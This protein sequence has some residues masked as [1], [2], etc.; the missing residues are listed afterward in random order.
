MKHCRRLG[1]ILWKSLQTLLRSFC[2]GIML[3]ESFTARLA[4]SEEH[5]TLNLRLV[6]LGPTLAAI[7]LQL[8]GLSRS[9]YC[10]GHSFYNFKCCPGISESALCHIN[11]S[12]GGISLPW[13]PSHPRIVTTSFLLRYFRFRPGGQPGGWWIN[14]G[15]RHCYFLMMSNGVQWFPSNPSKVLC[16]QRSCGRYS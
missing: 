3:G 8:Q 12:F 4:Q 9:N 13:S 14:G 1:R 10:H 5:E 15:T 16:F 6:G 11:I 7:P 2:F